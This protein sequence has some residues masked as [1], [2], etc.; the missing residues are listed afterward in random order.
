[1]RDWPA[2]S[3]K[4]RPGREAGGERP[5]ERDTSELQDARACQYQ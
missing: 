2:H 5:G 3:G 1:M 4:E